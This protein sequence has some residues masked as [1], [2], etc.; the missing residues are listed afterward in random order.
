MFPIPHAGSAPAPR[1]SRRLGSSQCSLP[2]GVSAKG[3][4]TV[5]FTATLEGIRVHETVDGLPCFRPMSQDDYRTMPKALRWA[6]YSPCD[7]AWMESF[8]EENRSMS[9]AQRSARYAAVKEIRA[10]N[11]EA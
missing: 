9:A 4:G 3:I 7:H 11:A 1:G 6:L 2:P 10:L 8:E 5:T